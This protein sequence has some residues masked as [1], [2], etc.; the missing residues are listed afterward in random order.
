MAKK[1]GR[2]APKSTRV[3]RLS[4]E[5]IVE[6]YLLDDLETGDFYA[7]PQVVPLH[8]DTLKH[9]R[10]R[11]LNVARETVTVD[12]KGKT[13]GGLSKVK[14]KKNDKNEAIKIDRRH[15]RGRFPYDIDITPL[16]RKKKAR[17]MMLKRKDVGA[18]PFRASDPEI[19][20]D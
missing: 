4:Q 11:F 1:R 13:V 14:V 9:F 8:P 6:V 20:V 10:I 5:E 3:E 7:F 18:L 12:F 2:G 15:P 16:G 17:T 19:I